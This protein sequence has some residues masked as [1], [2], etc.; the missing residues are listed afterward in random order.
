LYGK[1]SDTDQC[2]E[3]Y[4]KHGNWTPKMG[5]GPGAKIRAAILESNG[6]V[7]LKASVSINMLFVFLLFLA[8]LFMTFYLFTGDS[9]LLALIVFILVCVLLIRMDKL[10]KRMLLSL[11]ERYL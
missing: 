5:Y 11:L 2:F 9:I 7:I 8:C 10:N 4:A 3:F 1:F 6:K